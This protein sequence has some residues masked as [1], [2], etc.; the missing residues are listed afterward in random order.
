MSLKN[1]LLNDMKTA[2]REKDLLRKNTIQLVR[3]AILQYEKDNQVELDDSQII[4]I[5]ASQVKKRKS[6]IPEYEKA[7]RDDFVQNLNKEIEILMDYLP[8]QLSDDEIATA[9]DDIISKVGAE[10]MKDMGKV[11]GLAT[12]ELAGK[13]DNQKVSM[14]VKEKLS[15]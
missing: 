7:G 14:I 6:S 5:V 1:T 4:D 10:T 2:M 9:I 11:M 3:S 13:A 8:K 12:K 15:S